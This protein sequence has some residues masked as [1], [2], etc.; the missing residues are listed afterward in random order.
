MNTTIEYFFEQIFVTNRDFFRLKF[1]KNL[2]F[3]LN[4]TTHLLHATRT[5]HKSTRHNSLLPSSASHRRKE[6]K[7]LTSTFTQLTYQ[8]TFAIFFIFKNIFGSIFWAVDGRSGAPR[9]RCHRLKLNSPT[10][11]RN[12]AGLLISNYE[13][14][15]I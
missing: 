9:W 3:A 5:A 10:T 8:D 14:R 11:H 1:E 13:S 15:L 4:L 2:H 7:F 12:A 6:Q